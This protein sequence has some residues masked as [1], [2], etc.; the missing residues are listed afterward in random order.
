MW[1]GGLKFG[2]QWKL[3]ELADLRTLY[4]NSCRLQTPAEDLG[5]A[6][7]LLSKGKR[8]F[9]APLWSGIEAENSKI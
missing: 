3:L 2:G 7:A 9:C 8:Q 6:C 1:G 4:P 5:A